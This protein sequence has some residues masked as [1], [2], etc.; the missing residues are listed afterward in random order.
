[1]KPNKSLM[2]AAAIATAALISGCSTPD[3]RLIGRWRSNRPL[4]VATFPSGKHA[5]FDDLFGRL[6]ATYTR[7]YIHSELPPK[8]SEQPYRQ[9]V[10]YRVLASDT[11]STT[12]AW[13][14]TSTG[15]DTT[16]QLHFVS[17]NRYWISLG[18][19][20]RREYF[21]RINQ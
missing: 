9:R 15:H 18:S 19:R 11:D 12:I 2:T 21:D 5:F 8:G 17:P 14:D 7:R 13:R 20:G 16:I 6:T 1:M 10:P 3:S 4:S